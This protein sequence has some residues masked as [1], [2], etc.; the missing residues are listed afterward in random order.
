MHCIC[1][2]VVPTKFTGL[3]N[4]SVISTNQ[5][6]VTTNYRQAE[7]MLPGL[8]FFYEPSPIKVH[9]LQTRYIIGGL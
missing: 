1:P 9:I 4:R 7:R 3:R 6:S 5:F 2:Q 8:F